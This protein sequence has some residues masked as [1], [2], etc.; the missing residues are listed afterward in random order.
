MQSFACTL[1]PTTP[2][3]TCTPA[4]SSARAQPMLFSSSNRALSSIKAATAFP[5][6][7]ASMSAFTMGEL[8]PTRYRVI[9]MART[10]GSWAAWRMKLITGEKLS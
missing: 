2:Y 3:T 10:P 4:R 9:L 1:R 6:S 7:R 8:E 5:F